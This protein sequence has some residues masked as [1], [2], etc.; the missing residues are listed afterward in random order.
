[1]E[2]SRKKDEET[3]RHGLGQRVGVGVGGGGEGEMIILTKLEGKKKK[4]RCKGLKNEK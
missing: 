1:M 4:E 3:K 2:E